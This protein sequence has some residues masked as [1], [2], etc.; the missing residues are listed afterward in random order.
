GDLEASAPP[1]V[2]AEPQGELSHVAVRTARRGAPNA[3]L[4]EAMKALEPWRGRLVRLEIG[5]EGHQVREAT[6]EEASRWW[7]EH[8]P[9]LSVKP[10]VD[11]SVCDLPSLLELNLASSPHPPEACY[12]G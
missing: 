7:N 5:A 8:R 3:Y 11:A 10:V 4:A 9:R 2:P 12:G 6:I 1:T